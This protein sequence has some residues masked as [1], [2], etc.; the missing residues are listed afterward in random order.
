MSIRIISA[1]AGSGKTYRLTSEMVKL[2][3]GGVRPSGIIATTFTKKAA[4]ELQERVRI[5]LLEA[6]LMQEAEALTNALIGTVHGLGVKLLQRFAYEAGVSPEVSIMADEDQQM[7]FNQ[8]LSVVL[9]QERVEKVEALCDKLGLHKR[10][11]YDWRREVR[12]LA[13]IART[14]DFSADV[15]ADSKTKSFATFRTFLDDPEDL[16]EEEWNNQLLVLL[17]ET[18]QAIA[19]N[20]DATKK[21]GDLTRNLKQLKEQLK[22]RGYLHWHQWLK[23]SKSDPGAK[24]REDYSSLK[25]FANRHLAN[26]TFHRDIEEFIHHIFDLAIASIQE[27]ESYK[28]SRG[29]IDYTDMEVLV[30][31]LL[32]HPRVKAI[33]AKELDL[34]MVDEFQDTS[35]IQLEIF[36]KL[37][38]LAG[39]SVWVGDPKQSIYGFRGAE[40]ALMQAVIKEA[41]GVKPEDIQVY[42]WRSREDIV[43]AVN[44]L[45]TKAF[46]QIPPEQVALKPKRT[47][48]AA[49]DSINNANEPIELDDAIIHWHFEYEG[50][51]SPKKPWMEN[52]IA[53]SLKKLL[54]GNIQVLPKGS[55][56]YRSAQPG[57]VA[58]LCRT[59]SECLAIAEALNRT[60]FKA[61]IA[62]NGLLQTAEAKLVLACLK[63]LLNRYDSLSV[64]EILILAAGMSI[65]EVIE[66]RLHYLEKKEQGNNF[67]NWA[68][69]ESF[70]HQL[71]ALRLLTR[72]MT[73]A[74][75]L[76][77]LLEE[78]QLR[79][80]IIGWGNAGQRLENVE[81]LRKLAIQYEDNC[82]RLHMSASLGGFLLWLNRL[83]KEEQDAQGFG[84]NDQAVNVLTYHRSKGLEWPIVICHSLENRLRSNVFGINLVNEQS[85]IDFD[86]ILGNRWLRYWVNPYGDRIII[87]SALEE[88]IKESEA[89]QVAQEEALTEEA[90]LLY[91]GMTRARDYLVLP[92]RDVPTRWLN[93]TWHQGKEE[94]PTLDKDHV[95]TPWEWEGHWINKQTEIFVYDKDFTYTESEEPPFEF[96]TAP[97]GKVDFPN[98]AIDLH[99]EKKLIDD[100]LTQ[101]RPHQAYYKIWQLPFD[102]VPYQLAKALKS[103]LIAD[104]P[105]EPSEVRMAMAERLI[106]GYELG[107]FIAPHDFLDQGDQWQKY[108][109]K[110][111]QPKRIIRKQ[112]LT[113]AYQERFFQT[114]VDWV[115]ITDNGILLIQNSGFAG[116][117]K[118]WKRK[119][120][121]LGSWF[122]LSKMALAEAFDTTS[123][124][125]F[126]HFVLGGA[127]VEVD[128]Q[129]LPENPKKQKTFHQSKN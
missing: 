110:T 22:L 95:D 6:G 101:T 93:R 23:I 109:R 105:N 55:D 84:Q 100:L 57:D 122:F 81:A 43:Y 115:L 62:R 12:Q 119:A 33:L 103:F 106:Q 89:Y 72:D 3:S 26:A 107:E 120:Q 31:Q 21:T 91:V 70:V 36:I 25:L 34:L 124:R 52:C 48:I 94:V 58:I 90:R 7:M 28:K 117:P 8:S 67:I 35:P 56:Q 123:I 66:N 59:N 73:S 97:A 5:R 113:Y 80:I 98:A 86:N 88:R 79:H 96:F 127:L 92:S 16:A 60:G 83:E 102:V 61:A 87:N 126:V 77:F 49:P 129:V 53:E 44:A 112:S 47:K 85:A 114:V 29:L 2:L 69:E 108:I 45:F 46:A 32:D 4:A 68:E 19:N 11:H 74:E 75:L 71:D 37:S 14:N 13:E 104:N 50:K 20:E 51:R 63:Y 125:T 118:N 38:K 18:I 15:L 64:A 82:N 111:F 99:K 121:E 78:L 24:S 42:S 76:N 116:E 27:F 65:E 30:N 54:A 128:A 9:T 1:G 40:P 17:E 39:Q 10:G 41:G